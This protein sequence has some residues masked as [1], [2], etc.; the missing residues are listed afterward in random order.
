MSK[1]AN[2]AVLLGGLTKD[3]EVKHSQGGAWLRFSL[4]CGYSV[5]DAQT[6]EYKEAADYVPCVAFG[7]T[8]EAIGKYC[9]RGSQ[10]YVEGRIRM[11]K[12]KD[13]DGNDR[14]ET[15][16][17]VSEFCFAGGKRK[18]DGNARSG[19]DGRG[20]SGGRGDE[21]PTDFSQY[22][23]PGG[24]M[25]FQFRDGPDGAAEIADIPF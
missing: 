2:R 20:A 11:K 10:L 12:N 18:D 9:V 4:A 13:R 21:F 24:G 25:S 19:G 1:G 8:A 7:K 5:K 14:W 16:V 17:Y 3:P 23:Q 6:G 22:D 15:N